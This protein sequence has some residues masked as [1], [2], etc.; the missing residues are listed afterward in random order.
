[1]I[2][3]YYFPTPNGHKVTIFLEETKLDYR[4]QLI[5][6]LKGEQFD[7][8]FLQISPNNKIPAIVDHDP[9]DGEG[10]LAIFESG[11]ILRYLAQKT[12]RFYP[13]DFRRAWEVEQW[14]MWQMGGF[15]PMLG[16]N[17]H[18]NVY[19]P[20][21]IPYAQERYTQET[22]RLYGVLNQ[23]LRDRDYVAGE[24]SIADMAIYPWATGWQRQKQDLSKF[25]YVADY[26]QLIGSRNAVQRAYEKEESFRKIEPK[27]IKPDEWQHLFSNKTEE[28]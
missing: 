11:A 9:E 6:I 13:Q 20:E 4:I 28:P 24:Y 22:T 23:R 10:P 3:L 8:D 12:E 27:E 26:L 16:Q 21:P 7:A 25:P 19:A 17:H 15:G 1:M 2:D 18:F 14:L 5:D